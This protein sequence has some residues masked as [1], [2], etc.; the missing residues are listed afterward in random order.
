[1]AKVEIKVGQK[2]AWTSTSIGYSA[3][4]EGEVICVVPAG[5]YPFTRVDGR[6]G[7]TLPD[8]Q[9]IPYS[10]TRRGS[11]MP[12]GHTSYVVR[13]PDGTNGNFIYYWTS[14]CEQI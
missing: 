10:R 5:A 6:G 8:G 1:M 3:E 4:R 13:V 7:C 12:R 9:K 14:E 11:G 2:V